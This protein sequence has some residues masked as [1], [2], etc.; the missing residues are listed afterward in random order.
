MILCWQKQHLQIVIG[1][2]ITCWET[3]NTELHGD[4]EPVSALIRLHKLKVR[5][6]KAYANDNTSYVAN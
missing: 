2:C 4:T 3:R 6:A 5:F 1:G